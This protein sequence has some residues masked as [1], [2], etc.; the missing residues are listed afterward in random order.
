MV[1]ATIFDDRLLGSSSG[2]G[3]TT[4]NNSFQINSIPIETQI[5]LAISNLFKD[6]IM[7]KTHHYNN[8]DFGVFGIY[9]ARITTLTT[10]GEKFIVA[11]V[12]ND[13]HQIG[14]QKLL[15]SLKWSNFQARE[16][17]D[18]RKEFNG[19]D[20]QPQS[21][22]SDTGFSSSLLKDKIQLVKKTKQGYIYRTENLPIK[23]ELLFTNENDFYA[24]TGTV[25]SAID[26]FSTI[27]SFGN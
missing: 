8:D 23:I 19:I 24:S 5:R 15:S 26:I 21:Y 10:N 18:M 13:T 22:S 14:T 11:F 25:L 3:S 20:L 7:T 27:I 2:L 12:E 4:G 16:T 6:F 9:K 1:K 17:F